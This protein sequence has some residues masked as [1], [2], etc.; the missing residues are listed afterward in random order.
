MPRSSSVCGVIVCF[1]S[2][3]GIRT[4]M[5]V[6]VKIEHKKSFAREY[7]VPGV[8]LVNRLPQPVIGQSNKDSLCNFEPSERMV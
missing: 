4:V 1:R 8:T 6:L 7:F 2:C 3:D 5:T